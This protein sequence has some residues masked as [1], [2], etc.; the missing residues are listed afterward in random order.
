M[1]SPTRLDPSS[2]PYA[3]EHGCDGKERYPSASAALAAIKLFRKEGTLHRP[4]R[5]DAYECQFCGAWHLGNS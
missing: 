5:I 3:Y 4:S 2:E 1:T